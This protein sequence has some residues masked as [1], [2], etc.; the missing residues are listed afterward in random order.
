MILALFQFSLAPFV[1]HNIQSWEQDYSLGPCSLR[2]FTF[3]LRGRS[4]IFRSRR[5]ASG[6]SIGPLMHTSLTGRRQH[7]Y[8][9]A[10]PDLCASSLRLMSLVTP[11]YRVLSA[12][13]RRY[14]NH[15]F[16]PCWLNFRPHAA[17]LT[18]FSSFTFTQQTKQQYSDASQN[19]C[20]RSNC[21]LRELGGTK[22]FYY[23]QGYF[24][25]VLR[26]VKDGKE[27]DRFI[28]WQKVWEKFHNFNI[29]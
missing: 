22:L 9:L 25:L 27:N 18:K 12:Q 6:F 24:W 8:R 10:L 21:L 23:F 29:I 5:N 16:S 2:A 11:Q 7:V 15:G 19:Y 26:R 14:V 28:Y 20:C 13:R 1:R 4:F 17:L 3:N